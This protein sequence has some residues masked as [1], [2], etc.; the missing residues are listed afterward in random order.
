MILEKNYTQENLDSARKSCRE[1]N[2]SAMQQEQKT[3]TKQAAK[4]PA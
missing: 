4:A 2:A 1:P 3:E